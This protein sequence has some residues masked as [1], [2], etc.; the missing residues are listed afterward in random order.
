VL[1]GVGFT[2]EHPFHRFL[3]RDARARGLFGSADEI[4]RQSVGLSCSPSAAR[5]L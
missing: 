5:P 4:V 2:T 3:K 1:A